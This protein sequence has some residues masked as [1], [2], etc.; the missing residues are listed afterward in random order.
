MPDDI[1]IS[2]WQRRHEDLQDVDSRSVDRVTQTT[3]NPDVPLT[4]VL[5]GLRIHTHPSQITFL[6]WDRV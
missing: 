2:E 6:G 1:F 5:L 4:S 3:T